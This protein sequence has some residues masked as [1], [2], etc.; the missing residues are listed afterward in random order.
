MTEGVGATAGVSL[1]AERS[2]AVE[3]P[4]G[5][6]PGS[7]DGVDVGCAATSAAEVVDRRSPGNVTG[8]SPP[9]ADVVDRRSPGNVTGSSP[10]L[11]AKD[12]EGTTTT[13]LL[14]GLRGGT[15]TCTAEVVA[16][17][18]PAE[19]DGV[20]SERSPPVWTTDEVGEGA[21]AVVECG[22]APPLTRAVA[23]AAADVVAATGLPPPSPWVLLLTTAAATTA[24]VA[25]AAPVVATTA[26]PGEVLTEASAASFPVGKPE[27]V[28]E[29][30]QP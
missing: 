4:L 23:E 7:P 1:V 6:N 28:P 30:C 13:S 14:T 3:K 9:M 27:R 10:K 16:G 21:P 18:G 2:T 15:S 25:V 19:V 22:V 24:V 11:L 8:A 20:S 12:E 29:Q 26:L 17:V 5:R